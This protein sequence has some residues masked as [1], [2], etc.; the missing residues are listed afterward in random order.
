MAC[1]VCN[2]NIER[3]TGCYYRR[4]WIHKKCKDL[5]KIHWWRYVRK[6]TSK[7]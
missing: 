5:M 4:R 7:L 3:G 2:E 1:P 6:K